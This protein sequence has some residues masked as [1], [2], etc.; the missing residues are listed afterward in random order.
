MSLVIIPIFVL[1][2]VIYCWKD[3][4]K[5]KKEERTRKRDMEEAIK[6]AMLSSLRK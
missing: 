4:R 6:M 2:F 1:A 5:G 3:H